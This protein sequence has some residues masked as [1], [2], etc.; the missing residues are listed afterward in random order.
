MISKYFLLIVFLKEPELFLAHSLM[1][2]SISI[3]YKNSID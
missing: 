3:K 2:S 1:V